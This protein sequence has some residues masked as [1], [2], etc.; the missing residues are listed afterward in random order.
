MFD[1]VFQ[2]LRDTP[3]VGDQ[4]CSPGCWFD[5]RETAF[6]NFGED[7]P[8]CRIAIFGGG[9]VAQ[10]CLDA[11]LYHSPDAKARVIWGVGMSRKLAGS[12]HFKALQGLF[13][14]ISVRDP[15]LEG[16]D[17]VPCPSAMSPGF[18][19][20]A[21]ATRPVVLFEH[22]LKSA[23]IQRVPHIPSMTNHDC[24]MDEALGFIAS[25]EIVVTNSYHGAYWGMCLGRRVLCL[26]F[27]QKFEGFVTPPVMADPQDW[28]GA[29][30]RA[31]K[32]PDI[33]PHARAANRAYYEKV[34]NL[35]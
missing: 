30:S 18:D 11:G 26:P 35:L 33:L 25:G 3:N 13:D 24:S 28:V 27:S 31:E 15:G 32:R 6:Q 5:F 9:Q 29:L 7:A 19:T 34:M 4:V 2:H 10:Q 12:L 16:L 1:V 17:C 23:H 14:L 22:A 8:P 21:P 20:P